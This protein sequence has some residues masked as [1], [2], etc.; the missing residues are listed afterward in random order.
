MS[1]SK[2]LNKR[3]LAV[4]DDLFAGKLEEQAVLEKHHV[5]RSLFERWLTDER[6][7]EQFEQRIARAQRQSRMILARYAPAAAVKLMK[8]T[9]SKNQE[10]ARKACLDILSL[11][12]SSAGQE[13]PEVS[14]RLRTS[15][16]GL[17]PYPPKPPAGSWRRWPKGSRHLGGRHNADAMTQNAIGTAARAKQ[18]NRPVIGHNYSRRLSFPY[19]ATTCATA[20]RRRRRRNRTIRPKAT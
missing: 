13:S 5:S 17:R 7:A 11:H 1:K 16:I 14:L 6:L 15:T 20:E 18:R 8:L 19:G 9:D 4:L 3:Q 2:K 12:A 10:T